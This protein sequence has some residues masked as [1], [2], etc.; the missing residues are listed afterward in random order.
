MANSTSEIELEVRPLVSEDASALRL[1]SIPVPG[2]P[3]AAVLVETDLGPLVMPGGITT[4]A[5]IWS[6]ELVLPAP[7]PG[8]RFFPIQQTGMLLNP[9]VDADFLTLY[10]TAAMTSFQFP[11]A[12]TSFGG[13]HEFALGNVIICENVTGS[14]FMCQDAD[15]S[16]L[17]GFPFRLEDTVDSG[18]GTDTLLGVLQFTIATFGATDARLQWDGRWLGFASNVDL[19]S[20]FQTPFRFFRSS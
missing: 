6:V 19:S 8:Y 12:A 2:T 5:D 14:E 10:E 18:Q 9:S 11:G 3:Q 20:S 4:A 15:P 16:P 17:G 1:G 13:F 7:M